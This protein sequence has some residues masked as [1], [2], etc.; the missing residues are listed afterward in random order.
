MVILPTTEK[1][2]L[3]RQ[4]KRQKLLRAALPAVAGAVVAVAAVAAVMFW[5]RGVAPKRRI[6][7]T[8]PSARPEMRLFANV[9][10]IS[11]GRTI[12]QSRSTMRTAKRAHIR[13]FFSQQTRRSAVLSWYLTL[14]RPSHPSPILYS[15][16][17]PP[18]WRGAP[19][20]LL[21]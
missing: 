4:L 8:R 15:C 3:E 20:A 21:V 6:T 19:S 13:M 18:A 16:L 11:S 1:Q 7:G 14:M 17:L 9:L 12:S 10:S 2:A 5:P